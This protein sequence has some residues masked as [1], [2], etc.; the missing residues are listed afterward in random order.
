M[1]LMKK[2]K[3]RGAEQEGRWIGERWGRGGEGE[4]KEG[5]NEEERQKVEMFSG[6]RRYIP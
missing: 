2:Q 4:E 5:D 3:R 1:F 6:D